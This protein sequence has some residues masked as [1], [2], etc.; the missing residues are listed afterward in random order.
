MNVQQINAYSFVTMSFCFQFNKSQNLFFKS[1][2]WT[3]FGIL[4]NQI[5]AFN[6]VHHLNTPF[7]LEILKN[8]KEEGYLGL[9]D[10]NILPGPWSEQHTFGTLFLSRETTVDWQWYCGCRCHTWWALGQAVQSHTARETLRY[11]HRQ[12]LSVPGNTKF[13]VQQSR[14]MFANTNIKYT[15]F[16]QNV[17]QQ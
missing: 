13:T 10:P 5:F 4:R 14:F 9:P 16:K 17:H 3:S 6:W 2:L 7:Y 12:T 1:F 11:T 8:R 15:R